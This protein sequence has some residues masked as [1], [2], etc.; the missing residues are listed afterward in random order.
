MPKSLLTKKIERPVE[1]PP[2]N[3]F[4]RSSLFT[5]NASSLKVSAKQKKKDT[6]TVRISFI[7]HDR[8]NALLILLGYQSVDQLLDTLLGAYEETLESYQ[9]KE[10]KVVE[11]S[12]ASRRSRKKQE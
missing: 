1:N 4:D 7:N 6:T 11:K 2:E 9:K 10:L 8:L 12:L 5:V 3:T